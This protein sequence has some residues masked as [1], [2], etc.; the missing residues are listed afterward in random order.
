MIVLMPWLGLA[1]LL[2]VGLG[3]A[4]TG[5]PAA[6]VLLAVACFGA[7]MGAISG[8]V[9]TQLIGV[10]PERLIN[11]L[12]NDLLQAIPL[13]VLMGTLIN[14]L[15][16][17]EALYRCCLAVLPG[18]AAP[19]VSGVVLGGLL[20]LLV[21]AGLAELINHSG[22]RMPPPP[23]GTTGYP[24]IVDLVP[25]VFVGVFLLIVVTTVV[26]T[27]APAFKASRMKIVDALGH[28]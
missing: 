8:D 4:F 9:P 25:G 23:G 12:D 15:P 10:L 11:L 26:S 18:P 20:G 5:L 24:L 28:V 16:L 2:L 7:A 22:L 13:Y 17:A 1:L 3:I 6:V 14:R 21:A 19:A 27:I